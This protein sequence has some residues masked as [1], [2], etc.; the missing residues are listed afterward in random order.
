[1]TH[2]YNS[3]CFLILW[4]LNNQNND[5]QIEVQAGVRKWMY[6]RNGKTS[7]TANMQHITG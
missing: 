3:I 5:A 1:M 6:K 2:Q 7:P 4:D